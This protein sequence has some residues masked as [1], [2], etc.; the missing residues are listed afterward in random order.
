MGG[1]G[2]TQP[3]LFCVPEACDYFHPNDAGH[4]I[5]AQAVYKALFGT[6]LPAYDKN[7]DSI[8][9]PPKDKWFILYYL[10]LL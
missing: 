5:M 4:K 8:K 9:N 10:R 7:E 6:D 2:L 1:A 3:E